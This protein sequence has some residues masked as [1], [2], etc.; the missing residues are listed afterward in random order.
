MER[1]NSIIKPEIIHK[2]RY[3]STALNDESRIER[4]VLRQKKDPEYVPTFEIKIAQ[5]DD[6]LWFWAISCYTDGMGCG[7]G[8]FDGC[9]EYVRNRQDA[10]NAAALE[11]VDC[12]KRSKLNNHCI[13]WLL[14]ITQRSD[15]QDTLF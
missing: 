15:S 1:F 2:P 6:G 7:Y 13:K 14:D 4:L 10:I 9:G 5:R 3:K 12:Y 8:L 11:I